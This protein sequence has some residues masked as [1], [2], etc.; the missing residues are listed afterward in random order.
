MV[1]WSHPTSL[2]IG[3]HPYDEKQGSN[4]DVV[5]APVVIERLTWTKRSSNW[6]GQVAFPP[7]LFIFLDSRTDTDL[8]K[9]GP[10]E[11]LSLSPTKMPAVPVYSSHFFDVHKEYGAEFDLNE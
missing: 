7:T 1:V 9:V 2:P 5:A 10:M 11:F 3:T 8:S 4:Q 6:W